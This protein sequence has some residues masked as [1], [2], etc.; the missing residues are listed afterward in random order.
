MN[1]RFPT[2]GS[3][4]PI[5]KAD[6]PY[7]K[8]GQ[9]GPPNSPGSDKGGGCGCVAAIVAFFVAANVFKEAFTHTTPGFLGIFGGSR[10]VDWPP[11]VVLTAVCVFVAYRIGK[12]MGGS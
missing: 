12:K 7:L 8:G 3:E 2:P 4:K 9:S 11:V 6:I 10:E 1:P 5:S